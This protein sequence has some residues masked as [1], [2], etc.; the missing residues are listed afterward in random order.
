MNVIGLKTII[1]REIER[2]MR[3]Y[4]QSLIS[5]WISALL[6]IVV[7]GVIVGKNID[8]IAGVSYIDFVLP[9]IVMLTLIGSSF[10][11]TSFSLYFQRFAKHIEEILVSPL[12]YAEMI[13]GYVVGGV[14]RGLIAGV[15]V[16]VL[17]IFFTSATIAH[18]GLFLLYAIAVS[19]I[20][21]LLGLL[22]ALWANNFEQL[23]ILNT[24]VITPL[25]FLGGVFNSIHMLP[26]KA[27]FVVKLNPFFYF[28]DGLRYSMIGIQEGS[29]W[30]GL[31]IILGL[32]MVF[33][34]LVW[35]LFH[36]G[37]RLRT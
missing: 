36:R 9:G 14:V 13:T 10:S 11:Q 1:A 28:V 15:G 25:T 4:I 22:V 8:L 33:G 12:S 7:F 19:V 18:V 24:F 17:A 27:Q 37:W 30:I 16:Y 31:A 35:Y 29:V 21:S 6:Y 34:A 2:F 20:F 23:S 26:E 32:I 3:T 5:P